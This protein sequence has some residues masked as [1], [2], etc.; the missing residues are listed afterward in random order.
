MVGLPLAAE[1]RYSFK[2]AS[3][4]PDQA[5][6]M[7]VDQKTIHDLVFNPREG[8]SVEIKRWIDPTDPAGVQIIVRA[9]F[10]LR[11]RNGGFLVFGFDDKTLLPDST[12]R[13]NDVPSAFHQDKI[14]LIISRYASETFEI[15]IGFETRNGSEHAVIAVPPGVTA[16]VAVKTALTV[17]VQALLRLG[18]VY[19]RTLNANGTPSSARASPEDWRDLTDIC[20]ENREAVI[21]RFLRRHLTNAN[22]SA[23]SSISGLL[24]SDRGVA[25]PPTMKDRAVALLDDGGRR[26]ESSLASRKTSENDKPV[27]DAAKWSVGLVVEPPKSE[28]LADQLFLNTFCSSNPALNGWP[29]WID[30]RFFVDQAGHPVQKSGA[31]E[32]LIISVEGWSAHL[33][34]WRADPKGEFYLLRDLQDDTSDRVPP[35]KFL[36]PLLV[37]RRVTE[38]LAV[39][40]AV[41][42]A[43][44]WDSR[45]TRLGFAFRW[46]ALKGRQLSPWVDPF[47]TI[48]G[49]TAH[50]DDA[51]TYT[52]IDLATP[53]VALAPAVEQATKSLFVKFGGA[54][55]HPRVVEEIVPLVLSRR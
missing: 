46:T 36:D 14:Q 30:S 51:E 50:D 28:A 8:L 42:K 39:G 15:G 3:D 49:G 12:N 32:A 52:E 43:L 4:L 45:E 55:I 18:D 41:T 34:F 21:G 24:A 10:A 17:G 35:R 6:E 1:N 48:G 33:D 40:I 37:L 25:Q 13:P 38:V 11:N 9:C 26:F 22:L 19:F 5:A 53:A 20:F 31:W 23:L 47:A 29:A 16:P 54:T 2:W 27:L 44:G 7:V